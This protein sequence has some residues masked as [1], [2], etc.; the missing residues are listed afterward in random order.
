VDVDIKKFYLK[1]GK[2]FYF[3]VESANKMRIT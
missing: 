3:Y 2:T 1:L